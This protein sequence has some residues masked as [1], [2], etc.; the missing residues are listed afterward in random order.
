MGVICISSFFVSFVQNRLKPLG[1]KA[2]RG[3]YVLSKLWPNWPKTS[4]TLGAQGFQLFPTGFEFW[5]FGLLLARS[6]SRG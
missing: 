6:R 2:Y 5:P 4:T 1:H 3:F